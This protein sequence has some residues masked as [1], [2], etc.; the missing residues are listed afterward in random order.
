MK[1]IVF[2]DSE[3]TVKDNKIKDLGA[4]KDNGDSFHDSNIKEFGKFIGKPD[5]VCGHNIIDY[6]YKFLK[7]YI[8]SLFHHPLLIDT[9]P[10]S[11]LLFPKKPYHN[12]LKDD[13]IY[14]EEVNN[15]LNDAIKCRELFDSEVS[16]FNTLNDNLKRIYYGLLS[17]NPYFKNF[18]VYIGYKDNTN[19]VSLVK[20]IFKDN[21][22]DN[23]DITNLIKE[24]PV[25]LA[26][27]LAV[28]STKD[29]ESIIPHWVHMNYPMVDKVMDI[30]RETPCKE[31]CNYCSIKF[32]SRKRLKEFFGYDNFRTFDGVALQENAVNAAI[33]KE[34]ILTIFPT[35]GGKSI[36]FQLPALIAGETSRALTI[37]ISPLQSLMKDQVD[38]LNAK[39]IVDAVT[40]NGML[41]PV[42]RQES[43]ERVMNGMASILYISPETLRSKTLER[44]LLCRKIERIAIDEA[45]C[46]SSWGQDFRVD[47]LYIA[48]FVKNL[49]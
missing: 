47:Y 26:Y 25:E 37:V 30:L 49:E 29:K 19:L 23:A 39:G 35:G 14:T 41:S 42:E 43:I 4:I 16:A 44:I 6:D 1:T 20:E 36:T 28:I 9:L 2:I 3:I 11:P 40:I 27:C 5:F 34:S 12:L 48:E 46:F 33:N 45:H 7:D 21:I 38:N 8:N 22:C 32:D 10:I 18:F 17:D 31:G 13:K 15:P 24:Y